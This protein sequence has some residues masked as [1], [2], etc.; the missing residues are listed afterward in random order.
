MAE[1]RGL[2]EIGQMGEV[3]RR[4]TEMAIEAEDRG[5][6]Y[7]AVVAALHIATSG[8]AVDQPDESRVRL[9][10]AL[11]RWSRE[12]FLLQHLYAERAEV[13]ADLYQGRAAEAWQ[14]VQDTW[15]KIEGAFFLR[16]PITRI[17]SRLMR[18]RAA[19]AVAAT[20]SGGDANLLRMCEG[21][22][23]LLEKERRSDTTAH[24]AALRAGVAQVQ[25][26]REGALGLLDEAASA[27]ERAEMALSKLCV[28]RC[29]GELVGGEEGR[30][31]IERA[32]ALMSAAGVVAPSR[33]VAVCAPGFG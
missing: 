28:E 19:L 3:F 1:L 15:P 31:R 29:S 18:A 33:W 11:A 25:G 8:V 23:R 22:A 9:R 13:Y 4:A 32:D 26:D 7:G 24:A 2:E 5:D 20:G 30:E 17:D 12:G 27:Y 21:E 16:T 6:R 14:R 10:D